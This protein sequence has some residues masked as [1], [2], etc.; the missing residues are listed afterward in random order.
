MEPHGMHS[1]VL[2]EPASD[3]TKLLLTIF[4]RS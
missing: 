1:H 3:V 4:E 2:L